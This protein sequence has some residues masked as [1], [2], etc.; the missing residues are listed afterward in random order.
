MLPFHTG[1]FS[2]PSTC[3]H[4]HKI[5]LCG[6]LQMCCILKILN[7]HSIKYRYVLLIFLI[8]RVKFKHDN[9]LYTSLTS[10]K[11]KICNMVQPINCKYS[12]L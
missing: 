12:S 4:Q 7:K 1:P 5:C 11:Y 6:P 8:H 10:S 2:Q 3:Q 9:I